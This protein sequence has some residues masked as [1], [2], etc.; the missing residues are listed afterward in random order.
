MK[1]RVAWLG[2]AFL[3]LGCA[4]GGEQA[5][6]ESRQAGQEAPPQDS[7]APSYGRASVTG[8]VRVVGDVP[9]PAVLKMSADSYCN[10]THE[11][12][13]VLSE[14]IVV[15]AEGMLANAF[16]FVS[17]GL[18]GRLYEPPK[19]P[20]ILNQQGCMY[21]PHVLGMMVDQPLNLT[22][23]DDT[24]HNIH[25]LPKVEGNREFNLGMS[26]PGVQITKTFEKPEIMVKIKCDVHPWMSAYIG[27]LEHPFFAV[28]DGDGRYAIPRLPP[29]T[30]TLQVWHET[31]GT[32]SRTIT[33]EAAGTVEADFTYQATSS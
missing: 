28:T 2:L 32:Q 4:D 21:R 9:S 5:G 15:D 8:A 20:A 33:L 23:S 3:L 26:R 6:Q 12:R 13:E 25:A 10:E 16:V 31:F 22:N 30:Y 14:E 7:L 18:Q 1:R 24:L 17:D 11:D 19:E 29:G 27:V